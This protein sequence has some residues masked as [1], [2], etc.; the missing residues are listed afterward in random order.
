MLV[1]GRNNVKEVLN[2]DRNNIVVKRVFLQKNFN[3]NDILS[4][5]KK[6]NL[7][8][9]YKEKYDLDR[10]VKN[11]HQGVVLEVGD[12]E[13][14]DLEELLTKD[15]C[16]LL[17]LDHL[18]DPHNLGA[19]TRTVEALGV[20]GIILPLNRSVMVNETVVKTSTGAIYNTKICQVSNLNNTIKQ[21]KKNGFWIYGTDMNGVNY[22][23]EKY[24]PKCAIVIGNE[25]NG[26]SRIVRE[27]C[28]S[29]IS[30]PMVGKVNSLNASVAAGIVIS[31]VINR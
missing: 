24:S 5:V 28:D 27:A 6:W 31:E 3:E 20:D 7:E 29:I 16:F 4:L 11:N 23:E 21:L 30:I 13:Y 22:K 8:V 17:I 19:I 25:G 12:F 18:E 10:L 1:S 9:I 15:R 26:L 14:T 2:L